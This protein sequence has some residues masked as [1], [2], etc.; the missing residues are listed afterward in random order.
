MG[1]TTYGWTGIPVLYV[2]CWASGRR[3]SPLSV[4]ISKGVLDHLDLSNGTVAHDLADVITS[5]ADTAKVL[6]TYE[7]EEW[8]AMSGVPA[9]TLNIY[10]KGRACLCGLQTRS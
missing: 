7:A 6:A 1:T 5:V 10:G 3:T 9:V 2:M 4:L 8:T